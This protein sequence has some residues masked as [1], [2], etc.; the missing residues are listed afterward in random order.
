MSITKIA[1]LTSGGNAPG[2]NAC[3]RA[4]VR[5]GI[6]HGLTVIGV[7]RGY[8]GLLAADFQDMTL[9]SV[10]GI[11]NRGGTIL[12]TA[13]CAEFERPEGRQRAAQ[14]LREHGI[15]GLIVIGGS[16]SSRGALALYQETGFP[17]VTVASTIDNDIGGCD[18]S[19][20]FDTAVDTA[21]EAID[22][23]RETADSHERI[24][25]LEVMGRKAGFIA[26]ETALAG[27]AEVV[28]LPE[29]PWSLDDLCA[30]IAT[31]EARGKRSCLVVVAEGAGS[32]LEIAAEVA[33]RLG[34]ETRATILG[35][36]QRGG[37]P[38]ADDRV[39]AS[40]TGAAAVEALRRGERGKLVGMIG[41]RV[42]LTPLEEAC[43]AK[44][45]PDRALYELVNTLAI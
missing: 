17:L 44:K 42:A 11:I 9:Q 39:L 2:M 13:R 4:V 27:G 28:L 26:L 5:T 25:F 15:E 45:V 34:V 30:K 32:A 35:H 31:W 3:L 19:I 38:T 40:R 41:G 14:V 1:V 37:S 7:R 29:Y 8:A 24:F 23:L 22:R 21:V 16:G 36:L 20:G 6:F 33:T 18:F 43:Q 10:S 12:R